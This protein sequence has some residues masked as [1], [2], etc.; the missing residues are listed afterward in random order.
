MHRGDHR[1]LSRSRALRTAFG[2]PVGST[3]CGRREVAIKCE[4]RP[5]DANRMEAHPTPEPLEQFTVL[6]R[7]KYR[8]ERCYKNC[9]VPCR[10]TGSEFRQLVRAVRTICEGESHE[11]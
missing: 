3:G 6:L 7:S 1:A 8:C 4:D 5:A 10:F 11:A 9:Q 2:E